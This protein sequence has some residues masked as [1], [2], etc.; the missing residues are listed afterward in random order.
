M[1]N[2]IWSLHGITLDIYRKRLISGRSQVN[3]LHELLIGLDGE[4]EAT[5]ELHNSTTE[6]E[7]QAYGT[8]LTDYPCREPEEALAAVHE[9]LCDV[10]GIA[11]EADT[12]HAI[13]CISAA[14]RKL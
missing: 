6:R 9:A 7:E 1:N 13:N 11:G 5:E 2:T 10:L 8:K 14:T 4:S 12:Q 3:I